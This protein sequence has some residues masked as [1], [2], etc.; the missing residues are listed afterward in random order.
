MDREKISGTTSQVAPNSRLA[1]EDKPQSASFKDKRKKKKKSYKEKQSSE[2]TQ[3]RVWSNEINRQN[4]AFERYY[5]AQNLFEDEEEF[6]EFLSA[7]KTDLP[8]TFRVTGSRTTANDVNNI[9]RNVHVP[10]LTGIE[11]EGSIVSP[12]TPLPWYPGG[13]AW[14]VNVHKSVIRK[15][16]EFQNMQR[17]LVYETEVGN[18]S[19]QEA[20]SMLPP[21]VLDVEPH[22]RIIDMCAAPG[23]KTAQILEAM[24]T[25]PLGTSIPNPTGIIIAND[26][27]YKRAG[28][29]VH[30]SSRLPSPALVVT[31]VDASNY[32]GIRIGGQGQLLEFDRILCDVP[33]SG[34][35]T[36]RKNPIIWRDW[37]VAG[38]N[39]L[40]NLQ[41]RILQR[42]M[43]MLAPSGRIVYSTCSMNPVENE[44]VIASALKA[45]NGAYELVDLSDR[46][47]ELL[48]RPG[49]SNWQVCTDKEKLTMDS[50]FEEF[51]SRLT[52]KQRAETKIVETMFPC[53]DIEQFHLERCWRIYPHLQNT[54]GFFVAVFERSRTY[55]PPE[56]RKKATKRSAVERS[57][58]PDKESERT[59][60]RKRVDTGN[61]M[62]LDTEMETTKDAEDPEISTLVNEEDIQVKTSSYKEDPYTYVDPNHPTVD[63]FL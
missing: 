60:K 39:G 38:A 29:L 50:T 46:L 28:L 36:L 59:R 26:S 42:A 49:V 25:T 37:S 19:R 22:H 45:S 43:K 47:P 12:P 5:R 11:H 18:I 44:A 2:P 63:Q 54:G 34:D 30:Q 41:L 23:S 32:P 3:E 9:I 10:N 51:S 4:T 57:D 58:T 8:T 40:H 55:A 21:L 33:C 31:N 27:D 62:I 6:A 7:L 61:E 14:Q 15:V 24:H 52:E 35:G 48:R 20:V 1:A 16:P 56:P 17:F 53:P 13:F